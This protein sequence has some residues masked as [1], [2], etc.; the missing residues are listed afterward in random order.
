MRVIIGTEGFW[1]QETVYLIPGSI[2]LPDHEAIIT[3]NQSWGEA[4]GVATGLQREPHSHLLSMEVEFHP[5]FDGRYDERYMELSA[6]INNIKKFKA[7]RGEEPI[8]VVTYA[9]LRKLVII[10]KS[11]G[12]PVD[13]VKNLKEKTDG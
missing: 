1:H 10:P 8:D 11:P 12:I 4:V 9:N 7:R 13:F 2:K 6:F 5:K 3:S